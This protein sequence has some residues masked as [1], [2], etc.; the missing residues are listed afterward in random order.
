MLW[1]PT[2]P[3]CLGTPPLGALQA[4]QIEDFPAFRRRLGKARK[5]RRFCFPFALPALGEAKVASADAT[6]E[7]QKGVTP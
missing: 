6:Q 4:K 1:P 2:R 7:Q 5:F 3:G